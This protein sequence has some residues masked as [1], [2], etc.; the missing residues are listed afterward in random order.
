MDNQTLVIEAGKLVDK[1]SYSVVSEEEIISGDQFTATSSLTASV[2]LEKMEFVGSQIKSSD[3]P[4]LFAGIA[5]AV[6]AGILAGFFAKH[7]LSRKR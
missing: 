6:I 1:L 4:P 3:L 2:P 7:L 5:L